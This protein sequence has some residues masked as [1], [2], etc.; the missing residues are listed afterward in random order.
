MERLG[1]TSN[2]DLARRLWGGD[3]QAAGNIGRWLNEKSQPNYE[4]TMDMLVACGWLNMS[5][6]GRVP[7]KPRNH[8]EQIAGSLVALSE[9]QKTLL[10]HFG[11]A[12]SSPRDAAAK[13]QARP[14][15]RM[16]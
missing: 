11:L 9:G 8:L 3:P 2:A 15:R 5:A 1:V 4:K 12:E 10:E 6:G 13:R 14:K 16:G 7:A